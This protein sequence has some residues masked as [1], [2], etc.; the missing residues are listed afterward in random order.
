MMYSSFI[1]SRKNGAARK[2]TAII[3]LRYFGY[4]ANRRK[5]FIPNYEV[6]MAF[7]LALQTGSWSLSWVS[8]KDSLSW[9]QL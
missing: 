7:E 8:G 5:S 6:A 9:N 3:R 4:N 2:L 1:V